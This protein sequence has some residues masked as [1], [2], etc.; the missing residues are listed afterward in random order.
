MHRQFQDEQGRTWQVWEV[1]PTFAERR[2]LQKVVAVDRRS[3]NK[4]RASLPIEMREGWLAFETKGE[5]RRLA[6]TPVGWELLADAELVELL[7][8]ATSVGRV[9]RLIE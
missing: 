9:R 6:P 7:R 2:I 5:R 3:T 8:H 1:I 4:P